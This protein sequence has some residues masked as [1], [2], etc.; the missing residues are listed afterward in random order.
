MVGAAQI[1]EAG[2]SFHIL[3]QAFPVL[4]ICE[5]RV[6]ASAGWKRM[7]GFHPE[8]TGTPLTGIAMCSSPSRVATRTMAYRPS[9]V[10]GSGTLGTKIQTQKDPGRKYVAITS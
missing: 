9:P 4:G 3:F 10:S 5:T 2:H 8:S 1:M 6:P 7:V